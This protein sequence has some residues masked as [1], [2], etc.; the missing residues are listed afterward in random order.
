MLT[1]RPAICSVGFGNVPLSSRAIRRFAGDIQSPL[2]DKQRPHSYGAAP[3]SHQ[4]YLEGNPAAK[5]KS[6][7]STE[8]S[9][10]NQMCGKRRYYT[11]NSSTARLISLPVDLG[12]PWVLPL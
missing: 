5:G 7:P 2:P 10:I 3:D 8:P 11:D 9:A 6:C 12:K 1:S 4:R